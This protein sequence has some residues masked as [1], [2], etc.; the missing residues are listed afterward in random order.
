MKPPQ[1]WIFA[2]VA[3][4]LQ[5][6][7][8]ALIEARNRATQQARVAAPVAV[9]TVAQALAAGSIRIDAG[10]DEKHLHMLV[11]GMAARSRCAWHC[12]NRLHFA[13]IKPPAVMPF[14]LLNALSNQTV[15]NNLICSFAVLIVVQKQREIGILRAMGAGRR[16]IMA[17]FLLQGGLVG[18]VAKAAADLGRRADR[19]LGQGDRAGRRSGCQWLAAKRLQAAS[20]SAL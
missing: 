13:A 2:A 17:V 8:A 1:K 18:F 15:S 6:A 7:Q 16:Q 9:Q 14:E 11:L 12:R 4:S 20:T 5:Q 19:Q 10:I 3:L